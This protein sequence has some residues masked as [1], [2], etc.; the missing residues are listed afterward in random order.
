MT[1]PV[2]PHYLLYGI[3]TV[4]ETELADE[5]RK[6][7]EFEKDRAFQKCAEGEEPF[8]PLACHKVISI[9][10]MLLDSK[11]HVVR[12]GV[13]AGGSVEGDERLAVEKWN[14][15]AVESNPN[16]QPLSIVDWNGKK[17]DAP[18][19]QYRSFR[20]GIPMSWFFG[21]LPDN[22]GKISQWSKA[23]RDRYSG[24]HI[25]LVE[26]WTNHG[27]FRK[28]HLKD[29]AQ[30]MGLPGK[31]GIDGTKVYEAWKQER[32]QEIDD[33]CLEDV[34]HTGFVMMRMFFLTGKLT[35]EE[36]VAAA[37]L[38]LTHVTKSSGHK[39][40]TEGEGHKAFVEA[41]NED[42]LLLKS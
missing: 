4:P 8:P 10:V 16:G 21:K 27:A 18:V 25:D 42:R 6:S 29:L 41:I 12:S 28:C 33:Y 22:H 9:G 1:I 40:A 15:L 31:V 7:D 19:L 38:L 5:W 17:F 32:H 11:L 14:Q 35:R 2:K 36:Y 34:W 30:L 3:E 24:K 37:E 23:Y 26:Y 39:D 13:L 20:Y